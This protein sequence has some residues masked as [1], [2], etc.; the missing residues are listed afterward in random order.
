VPISAEDA[1]DMALNKALVRTILEHAQDYPWVMQEIGL[2]GLR[3]DDSREY[4]LHVWDPSSSVGEPPV[5]DHPFDFTS[6]IIAGEM[7]NTLY[8]ES[9]S[10]VEYSRVR[11]PPNDEDARRPDADTVRLLAT[12]TT[13]GEG[14][15]YSQLAHQLHDSRQ[16]PGTVTVIRRSFREVPELTVCR[17]EESPW[18]S[19]RSRP[20]RPEEI[21]EITAKALEW[22]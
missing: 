7:T 8:T 14:G 18:V 9:P 16:S 12:V 17:L 6:A 21:K 10:G 13:Y 2:L 19:G 11:Y 22:F 3:L 5:H 20:A 4:R 15:Q 1:M